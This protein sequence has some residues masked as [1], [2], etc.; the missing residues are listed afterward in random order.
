[1]YTSK[2]PVDREGNPLMDA[3]KLTS[4]QAASLRWAAKATASTTILPAAM[5]VPEVP[6]EKSTN[7]LELPAPSR[8]EGAGEPTQGKSGMATRSRSKQEKGDQRASI[9]LVPVTRK[10][11]NRAG[12]LRAMIGSG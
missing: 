1:M 10:R 11:A 7:K 2:I 9:E 8:I 12:S 4:E 6:V 5:I 3:H